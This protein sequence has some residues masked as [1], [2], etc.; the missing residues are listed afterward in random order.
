[1]AI[2]E[3][4]PFRC[5]LPTGIRWIPTSPKEDPKTPVLFEDCREQKFGGCVLQK[6]IK[7]KMGGTPW[8]LP[9]GSVNSLLWKIAMYNG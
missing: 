9:S 5:G 4:Q 7:T 6:S 2:R 1:M 3:V 8:R